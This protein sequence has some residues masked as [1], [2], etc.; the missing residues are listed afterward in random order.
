[1][2][3]NGL[4][5]SGVVHLEVD[6]LLPDFYRGVRVPFSY[7]AKAPTIIG[8]FE[9][10][11]FSHKVLSNGVQGLKGSVVGWGGVYGEL[12]W[13]RDVLE[14]LVLIVVRESFRIRRETGREGWC[15]LGDMRVQ[16]IDKTAAPKR[17]FSFP[18][19]HVF[20]KQ[21]TWWVSQHGP[22][23]ICRAQVIER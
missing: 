5:K 13:D 3:S 22:E 1:M 23:S 16:I 2:A 14:H 19:G 12:G 17:G 7:L 18:R 21:L 4:S 8:P 10:D 20:D 6:Y 11:V 9:E 15:V